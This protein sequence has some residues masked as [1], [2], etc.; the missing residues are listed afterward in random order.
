VVNPSANPAQEQER[1]DTRRPSG[2]NWALD[3]TVSVDQSALT[4]ESREIA[5]AAGDVLYSGSGVRESEATAVVSATGARTYY[6]RTTQLVES[7]HPKLHVEEVVS[8]V[9]R[10]LFV[11]SL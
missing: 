3:G 9:V 1:A 4:G 11:S 2:P 6:G 10:W 7:A 5:R 8:R